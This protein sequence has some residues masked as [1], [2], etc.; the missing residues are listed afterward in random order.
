MI[1]IGNINRFPR[2]LPIVPY[3]QRRD[4]KPVE[5]ILERLRQEEDGSETRSKQLAAIRYY[6]QY[7]LSHCEIKWKESIMNGISNYK[8]LLDQIEYSSK[9]RQRACLVTF[10]YDTLIEDALPSVG[11][12]IKA[13]EDYTGNAE[14]SLIKLHGSI[15]WGRHVE[16]PVLSTDGNAWSVMSQLIEAAPHIRLSPEFSLV[17]EQ[18][19]PPHQHMGTLLFPALAI[20]VETKKSFECPES[21]LGFLRDMIPKVRRLLVVGWRGAEAHFVDILRENLHDDVRIMVVAGPG[22]N[23]TDVIDRLRNAGVP[24]SCVA[25]EGGFTDFVVRREIDAF[26]K[27]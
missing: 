8:T 2:C 23:G 18:R 6:L 21:H 5:A 4:D 27:E 12:S 24:G 15:N 22:R 10:N 7:M 26:L 9:N 16:I 1:A 17:N 13:I 19:L 20:P 3:L 25:T 14:Y 11:I